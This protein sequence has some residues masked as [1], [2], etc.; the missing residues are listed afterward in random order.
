MGLW[1]E[2]SLISATPPASGRRL[3]ASVAL[4]DDGSGSEAHGTVVESLRGTDTA[5]LPLSP[6]CAVMHLSSCSDRAPR[7]APVLCAVCVVGRVVFHSAWAVPPSEL[8]TSASGSGAPSTVATCDIFRSKNTEVLRDT[9]V[10]AGEMHAAWFFTV[11]PDGLPPT[12]H[13][14]AIKHLYAVVATAVLGGGAAPVTVQLPFQ[15]TLAQETQWRPH[16]LLP[17]Q[18]PAVLGAIH[19][20][21]RGAGAAK[22]PLDEGEEEELLQRLSWVQD[23][24]PAASATGVVAWPRGCVRG[25]QMARLSSA[26]PSPAA[27]IGGLR[28]VPGR[29]GSSRGDGSIADSGRV[30]C[31][32]ER[33]TTR[34][35]P[36][37]TALEH[38]R[39]WQP[40]SRMFIADGCSALARSAP[41]GWAAVFASTVH[42]YVQAGGGSAGPN[43][44]RNGHGYSL[45]RECSVSSAMA[46]SDHDKQKHSV[47]RRRRRN[48]RQLWS[49]QGP[50]AAAAAAGSGEGTTAG[51]NDSATVSFKLRVCN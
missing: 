4:V 3:Q 12:L 18:A 38:A 13:G 40:R 27:V 8:A 32:W 49:T 17:A 25:Q 29:A 30:R 5:A 37:E 36:L 23:Q 7:A 1:L 50:A 2:M 31:C 21:T 35:M 6:M 44:R 46:A 14:T 28:A 24:V 10:R 26:P 16:G 20:P 33:H 19:L 51:G 9:R 47:R 22:A 15:L 34:G 11:L 45:A 48:R 39:S 41:G 43:A 42:E